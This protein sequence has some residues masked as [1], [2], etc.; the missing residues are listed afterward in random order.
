M[1]QL[2][3]QQDKLQKEAQINKDEIKRLEKEAELVKAANA[4]KEENA[5]KTQA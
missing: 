2:N 3:L 4:Q 1:E 5:G